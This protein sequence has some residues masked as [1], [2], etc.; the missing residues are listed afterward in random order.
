MN[1]WDEQEKIFESGHDPGI[2]GTGGRRIRGGDTLICSKGSF[3]LKSAFINATKAAGMFIV[4]A[5]L[6]VS[7]G[8]G[9]DYF[10]APRNVAHHGAD[11]PFSE[12]DLQTTEEDSPS[13]IVNKQMTKRLILSILEKEPGLDPLDISIRLNIDLDPT[14]ELCAEM[15]REGILGEDSVDG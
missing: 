7:S 1:L 15:V 11:L 9:S 12:G 5:A 2:F 13:F 8:A 4:S 6:L 14:A 10:Y 3:S